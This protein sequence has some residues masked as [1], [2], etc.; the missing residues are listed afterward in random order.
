AA[1]RKNQTR[2]NVVDL[3]G[4]GGSGGK[5]LKAVEQP[6]FEAAGVGLVLSPDGRRTAYLANLAGRAGVCVDGKFAEVGDS[7]AFPGPAFSLDGKH[8]V[9]IAQQGARWRLIID[10]TPASTEFAGP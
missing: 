9:W 8:V 3:A 4:P 7:F 5:P 6:P 2:L 1:R 10:G